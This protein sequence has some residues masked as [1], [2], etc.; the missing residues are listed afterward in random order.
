MSD[1]I[2]TAHC[3]RCDTGVR[4]THLGGFHRDNATGAW[5]HDYC[6]REA[7]KDSAAR[8]RAELDQAEHVIE[9]VTDALRDA[10]ILLRG[11]RDAPSGKHAEMVAQAFTMVDAQATVLENYSNELMG[12]PF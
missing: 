11:L 4:S 8:R 5:W 10:V 2:N 12:A 9:S 7:R 1:T 6:K 3:E